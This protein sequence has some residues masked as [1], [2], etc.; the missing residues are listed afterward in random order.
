VTAHC[1]QGRLIHNARFY[2]ESIQTWF[3]SDHDVL[4]GDELAYKSVADTLDAL[5]CNLL[6]TEIMQEWRR[7]GKDAHVL[8]NVTKGINA[9]DWNKVDRNTFLQ[10]AVLLDE[11]HKDVVRTHSD[12]SFYLDNKGQRRYAALERI[13]FTYGQ[14]HPGIRYVQGM[15]EIVSVLYYVLARDAHIEWSRHA[16]ADAYCLLETIMSDLRDVF[17]PALDNEDTGIQGRLQ[18]LEILLRKHDVQLYEHLRDVGIDTSFFAIRWWTT[19]LSREFLLPDTIR[20]WDSM[21]SSTHKDNFLRYVC[22]T[23]VILIRD[24]LLQ[25]DFSHGLR[26]LQAYPSTHMDRL[27]DA[28]RALWMY[29]SQ[30][31]LACHKG[32]L[33]LHQALSLIE[34]PEALIM[35]YGL[36]RGRLPWTQRMNEQTWKEAVAA[37]AQGWLGKA[38]RFYKKVQA[39]VPKTVSN[40]EKQQESHVQEEQGGLMATDDEDDDVYMEA[41][42]NVE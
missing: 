28:S 1:G 26:L 10:G 40:E 22:I 12:L 3:Q 6:P 35:A 30:I 16:E 15:N 41:I 13:L 24:D 29:E 7:R 25:T 17:V 23:M 11:I 19:L 20:L 42:R 39:N 32:N 38:N 2:L 34:P 36:K 5:Q 18:A 4:H 14:Y 31:T 21:L 33:T 9:L 8:V 27:L 37:S